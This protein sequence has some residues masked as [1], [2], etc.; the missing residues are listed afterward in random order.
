M[1]VHLNTVEEE[2]RPCEPFLRVIYRSPSKV[3][4]YSGY[5]LQPQLQ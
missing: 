4:N 1:S 2:I 5:L 3:S